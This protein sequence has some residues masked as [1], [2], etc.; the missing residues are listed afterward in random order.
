MAT[1]LWNNEGILVIDCVLKR[2][3][4]N[5]QYYANL[6]AQ[7]RKVFIQKT[8]EKLAHGVIFLQGD[9]PV[10]TARVARQALRDPI[11]QK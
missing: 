11:S 10:A 9:E 6:W 5:G 2:N 4:T 3:A 1:V 7:P 8:R